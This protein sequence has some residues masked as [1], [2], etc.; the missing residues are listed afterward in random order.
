MGSLTLLSEGCGLLQRINNAT[1]GQIH[2]L[3][4][5]AH[6]HWRGKNILF[7]DRIKGK[8]FVLFLITANLH[9]KEM[10]G[11]EEFP[12]WREDVCGFRFAVVKTSWGGF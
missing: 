8:R 1:D 11:E 2:L 7:L 12:I 9:F 6:Q 10:F 3:D 5:A 4:A